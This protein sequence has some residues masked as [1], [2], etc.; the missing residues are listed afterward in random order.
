M[1]V[2][3]D[4]DLQMGNK[5]VLSRTAQLITKNK[6]QGEQAPSTPRFQMQ[7]KGKDSSAKESE[8]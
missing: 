3:R 5:P 8:E 6:I 4:V 7:A 2:L 1:A